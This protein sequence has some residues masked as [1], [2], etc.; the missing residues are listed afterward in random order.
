MIQMEEEYTEKDY[1]DLIKD[2]IGHIVDACIG[3]RTWV[4]VVV[5]IAFEL[6]SMCAR[7]VILPS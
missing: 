4:I 2:M 5:M 3:H 1:D 6:T 7:L